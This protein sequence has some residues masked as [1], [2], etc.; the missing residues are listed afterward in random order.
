MNFYIKWL[1]GLRYVKISSGDV[2]NKKKRESFYIFYSIFLL[3]GKLV[4]KKK[5]KQFYN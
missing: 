2:V 3:F 1:C 4:Q 5:N